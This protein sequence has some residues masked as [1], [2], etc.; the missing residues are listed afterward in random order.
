MGSGHPGRYESH[1]VTRFDGLIQV[2]HPVID[3]YPLDPFQGKIEIQ[4]D[5]FSF[6]AIWRDAHVRAR[7]EAAFFPDGVQAP[8]H[9]DMDG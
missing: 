6:A 9:P 5:V 2:V 7:P 4:G 3:E 1:L 8:E